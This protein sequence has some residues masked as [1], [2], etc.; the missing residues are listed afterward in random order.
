MPQK[1]EAQ[2]KR[3]RRAI[4]AGIIAEAIQKWRPRVAPST[5]RFCSTTSSSA[6][7]HGPP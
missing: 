6:I 7:S 4:E 2:A 1:F 5:A 3:Q